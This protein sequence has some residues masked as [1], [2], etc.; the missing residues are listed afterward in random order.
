MLLSSELGRKT[1][2]LSEPSADSGETSNEGT[3][4][5]DRSR[6]AQWCAR[7]RSCQVW[8]PSKLS[9]AMLP[10]RRRVPEG[11]APAVFHPA[12]RWAHQLH[13]G[14]EIGK[15]K[16]AKG[17]PLP[18]S[19]WKLQHQVHLFRCKSWNHGVMCSFAGGWGDRDQAAEEG[20][21]A[22]S[23]SDARFY[24]AFCAEKV[25]NF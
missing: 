9:I 4:W 24:Q 10:R 25:W 5:T 11:H 15:E 12:G 2:P 3:H 21:G 23:T 1:Q 14:S 19:I 17:I 20:A 18:P 13:R 7:N 8:S 6:A 16:T 22:E